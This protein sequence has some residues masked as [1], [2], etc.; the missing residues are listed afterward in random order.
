MTT[1]ID[2]NWR[3]W[4]WRGKIAIVFH[5]CAKNRISIRS[6][7][8]AAPSALSLTQYFTQHLS[9]I[10]HL[11]LD[12]TDFLSRFSSFWAMLIVTITKK[13]IFFHFVFF[14][15]PTSFK[16]LC[17]SQNFRFDGFCYNVNFYQQWPSC[18]NQGSLCLALSVRPTIFPTGNSL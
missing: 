18:V 14:K 15:L 9:V 8:K 6:P 5:V 2:T 12:V 16:T 17:I 4:A 10:L 13:I 1:H 7:T 3:K 11:S